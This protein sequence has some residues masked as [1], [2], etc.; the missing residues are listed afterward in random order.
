MQFQ[1]LAQAG[2]TMKRKEG[3][4]RGETEDEAMERLTEERGQR[5]WRLF[6]I[7]WY[8]NIAL[9]V[10]VLLCALYFLGQA[11]AGEPS[12]SLKN[13]VMMAAMLIIAAVLLMGAGV[14]R[15]Q[16]RVEGQHLELKLAIK[17][18]MAKL[19]TMK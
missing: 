3:A 16:A 11:W 9:V 7:G 14:S 1:H 15:Y 2:R 12:Q 6:H 17:Q 10:I 4:R 8:F 13:T 19:D 18:I 5:T